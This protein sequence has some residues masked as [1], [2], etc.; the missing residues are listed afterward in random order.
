MSDVGSLVPSRFPCDAVS[1]FFHH[2]AG[3]SPF[4][5]FE[6]K[7]PIQAVLHVAGVATG[8]FGVGRIGGGWCTVW[9]ALDAQVMFD[10]GWMLPMGQEDVDPRPG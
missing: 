10:G 5:S 6:E 8:P 1:M 9:R 7:M 2:R 4:P 3:E